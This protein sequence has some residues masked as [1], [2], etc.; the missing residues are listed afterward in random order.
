MKLPDQFVNPGSYGAFRLS[1]IP[2]TIVSLLTKERPECRLPEP[3]LKGLFRDYEKAVLFIVNGFGWCTFDHI[4]CNSGFLREMIRRG[5]LLKLAAQFPSTTTCNITTLNTGLNVAQHGMFEWFYYEPVV[6]DIIAPLLYSYGREQMHRGTLKKVKGLK[7][8]DI[9][10]AKS[11]YKDLNDLGV[12]C[13]AYQDKS[14]SGSP[15]SDIVFRTAEMRGYGTPAEGLAD[16]AEMV[17]RSGKA[18]HSYYYD[19]V[20]YLLHRFGPHSC[21][22]EADILAFFKDLENMFWNKV[23]DK[24]RD[25]A[26]IVTADHGHTPIDYTKTIYLNQK[27]PELERYMKRN[28]EGR[29]LVPAGSC[30]AMFLY[31]KDEHL[32]EAQAQLQDLLKDIAIVCRVSDL[33]EHCFFIER[34]ISQ[35]LACRLGNLV[36]LPFTDV[37]VWWYVK[38]VFYI[39]Y[40]GHHGGLTREE[41]EI[42]FLMWNSDSR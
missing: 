16:M 4:A 1:N 2:G 28:R 35:T 33:V 32:E 6:D 24:A 29:P 23:R 30:R 17:G 3:S 36:I 13:Y 14:F 5:V 38:D 9:Y 11:F 37:P 39:D 8:E 20:D 27:L 18:F 25:I 22:V 10:P 42:P 19:R 34:H 12:K 26:F 41:L 21:E 31:I 7:P 40:L 15:Y